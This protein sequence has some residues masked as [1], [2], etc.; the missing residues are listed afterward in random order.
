[1]TAASAASAV[2]GRGSRPASAGLRR[3]HAQILRQLALMAELARG[4]EAELAARV[5]AVSG[6]SVA[7]QLEHLVLV[8]RA[9]LK[10]VLRILDGPHGRSPQLAPPTPPTPP[11]PPGINLLG[12]VVLGIGF[13]PRGR[14]RTLPPFQPG[15]A[16]TAAAGSGVVGIAEI[17]RGMRQLE[18]RLGELE[19]S[20][21]RSR[22]PLF[23]GLG[24]RQWLRFV[25]VHHHHHLKI[26][27]DIRRARGLATAGL[28]SR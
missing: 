7:E 19:A 16:L 6:W 1:M 23:G 12:R 4:P 3:V 9:V 13:I 21:S 15:A 5:P 17:E 14:A 26:V 2:S 11:A 27:R 22:H 8:D 28:P 24:G 18:P 25:T 20:G 10:S